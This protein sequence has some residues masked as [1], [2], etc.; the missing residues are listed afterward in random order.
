MLHIYDG[1]NLSY[2]VSALRAMILPSYHMSGAPSP[3]KGSGTSED[4]LLRMTRMQRVHTSVLYTCSNEWQL[5]NNNSLILL[6]P[7]GTRPGG[8]CLPTGTLCWSVCDSCTKSRIDESHALSGC[9]PCA[10]AQNE[11]NMKNM[12]PAGADPGGGGLGPP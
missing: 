10:C 7:R 2:P 12:L 3:L 1:E 6:K 5:S 11:V 4:N 9:G 8:E